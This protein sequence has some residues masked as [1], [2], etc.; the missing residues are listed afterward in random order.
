MFKI[1]SLYLKYKAFNAMIVVSFFWG[2]PFLQQQNISDNK[3]VIQQHVTVQDSLFNPFTFEDLRVPFKDEYEKMTRLKPDEVCTVVDK[4]FQEAGINLEKNYYYKKDSIVVVLDGYD[5]DLNIGY[6]WVD[7]NKMGDGMI[8]RQKIYYDEV[9]NESFLNYGA[10][11]M[12]WFEEKLEELVNKGVYPEKFKKRFEAAQNM[13]NDEK[14]LLAFKKIYL[15]C[16]IYSDVYR[17][18]GDYY[19]NISLKNSFQKKKKAYHKKLLTR[20]M[21]PHRPN[22]RIRIQ[23]LDSIMDLTMKK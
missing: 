14:K 7:W 10:D 20:R 2:I 3:P 6:V 19:K 8:N 4:I 16:M 13:K 21:N 18:L 23:I 9:L 11:K 1:K 5:P 12:L 15:D 22:P 17:G